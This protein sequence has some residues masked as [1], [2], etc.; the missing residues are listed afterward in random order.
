MYYDPVFLLRRGV[1][2]HRVP[3]VR[4]RRTL[5]DPPYALFPLSRREVGDVWM[6]ATCTA[7]DVDSVRGWDTALVDFAPEV[8]YP[9]ELLQLFLDVLR[10]QKFPDGV[11][12]SFE[13]WTEACRQPVETLTVLY[14]CAECSVPRRFAARALLDGLLRAPVFTC[15]SVSHTCKR[16]TNELIWQLPEEVSRGASASKAVSTLSVFPLRQ[17]RNATHPTT[18]I[19]SPVL[20]RPFPS[21]TPGVRVTEHRPWSGPERPRTFRLDDDIDPSD[22]VSNVSLSSR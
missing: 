22:S 5:D 12:V 1:T 20:T 21:E 13:A 6:G 4:L 7:W 2:S 19:A 18:H 16:T 15:S 3:A 10:T 9:F 8:G 11:V 14:P 17:S